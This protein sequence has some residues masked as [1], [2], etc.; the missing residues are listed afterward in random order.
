MGTQPRGDAGE[1]AGKKPDVEHVGPV[2]LLIGGEQVKQQ[3]AQGCLVQHGSHV[4]VPR[5]VPAAAAAMREHHDPARLVR[6]GQ[7]PGEADRPR[8]D[9][10][11]F[12]PVRR[13]TH[14]RGAGARHGHRRCSGARQRHRRGGALQA[15]GH[16]IVG[17][18]GEVS[19]ELPDGGERSRGL[20]ADQF[21]GVVPHARPPPWRRHGNGQHHPGRALGPGDLAGGPRRRPGCDP[22]V[23]HHRDTAAQRLTWPAMPV[24]KR[25]ALQFTAFP[26]LH[27]GQ[28]IRG[29]PA[30][31]DDLLVQNT[32][33]VLTDGPHAQLR[34]KRHPELA[35][36]DHIQRR[37][38][39]PGHLKSHRDA[40]PRQAKHHHPLPAQML[41]PRRQVPS[42]IGAISET[43]RAPPPRQ[44]PPVSRVLPAEAAHQGPSS[45][46][47]GC[48]LQQR[49]VDSPRL[50]PGTPCS[51]GLQSQVLAVVI[52]PL[53]PVTRAVP[54][55][56]KA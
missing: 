52:R 28:L 11:I 15:G 31:L 19:V 26:C 27:R 24:A 18:L 44:P 7:L 16:F 4:A 33:P 12:V 23:D 13:V 48:P 10:D 40:A 25:A 50:G 20:H 39:R 49:E 55:L 53:H 56:F 45:P 2:R 34:L 41:Q 38:E 37:A 32:H 17:R 30:P 47:A 5:A 29:D 42:R 22:V 3:R 1:P 6:H 46:Q 51:R 35:H 21:V 36:H 8:A 9:L 14:R 54:E 43:H